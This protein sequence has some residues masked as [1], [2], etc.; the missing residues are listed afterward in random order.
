MPRTGRVLR[1]QEPDAEHL[2]QTGLDP[3]LQLHFQPHRRSGQ[4]YVLPARV[5]S[6]QHQLG[7]QRPLL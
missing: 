5:S 4:L 3:P 7:H 6:E 1:R 2:L